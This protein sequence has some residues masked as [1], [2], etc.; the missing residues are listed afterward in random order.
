VRTTPK[1]EGHLDITSEQGYIRGHRYTAGEVPGSASIPPP[2]K[3][4]DTPPAYWIRVTN[5]ALIERVI[6]HFLCSLL[7][8][9]F[10]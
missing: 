8:L 3:A 7:S 10:F 2:I 5:K 4:I 1:K 9:D 6:W